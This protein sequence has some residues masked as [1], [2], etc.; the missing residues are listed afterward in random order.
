MVGGQGVEVHS[1]VIIGALTALASA[2]SVVARTAYAELQRDRDFLRNE[3]LN[4]LNAIAE[5]G[6]L[7]LT[8]RDAAVRR[9]EDKLNAALSLLRG[10]KG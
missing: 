4:T 8:T 2:L 6:R 7:A 9:I 1:S 5:S 10:R 3:V